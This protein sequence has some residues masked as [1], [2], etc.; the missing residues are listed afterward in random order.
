[1][2]DRAAKAARALTAEGLEPRDLSAP[3]SLLDSSE[4][5][6]RFLRGGSLRLAAYGAGVLA[7][8]ASVPLVARHLKPADWGHYLTVTS[9]LFI[10]QALTEGGVANVG[11]RQFTNTAD[12]ER[13]Q[14]MRDLLG[15]RIA[16]TLVGVIGALLFALAAGY[17]SVLVEGTAIAGAGLLLLNLQF[18]LTVPL[19]AEMRLGWQAVNDFLG[20]LVTALGMIALV[21]AGA[22]LLPFY[23]V[24]SLAAATTLALTVGLVRRESALTPA[25]HSARWRALLSESAVYAAATALGAVYF[26]IVILAMSLIATALETGCFSLSFRVLDVVNAVPWLLV[27]S[28]FPILARAARDDPQRLRYALQRLFEGGIVLGGWFALTL[29]AGAPFAISVIGGPSYHPSVELLRILGAGVPA[30]FLLATWSFA[31]LSLQLYRE[32]VTVNALI[33]LVAVALSTGLISADGATGAALVT[34]SLEVLLA[35]GYL[36]ALTRRRPDLRPHLGTVPRSAA[37][38]A[39]AFVPAVLLRQHSVL[40]T[41]AGSAVLL[42][43]L[44]LLRAMPEEILEL[45]R[46]RRASRGQPPPSSS[47]PQSGR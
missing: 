27:T 36:L 35:A 37:A 46:E 3:A 45:L 18:T 34:V 40:A 23:A 43:A 13:R 41:V 4:A 16:L 12:A 7:S 30:T 1:M 19:M 20:Q 6:R 44:L 47:T 17:S 11:V 33:V 24:S 25:F 29:V 31:L 15:L 38:L 9:L 2:D 10:V 28:A 14:L 32:L 26:R 8:L 42:A 22:T 5:G 21:I 39:L